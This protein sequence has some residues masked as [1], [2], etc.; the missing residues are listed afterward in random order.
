MNGEFVDVG[1]LDVEADV[2][3]GVPEVVVGGEVFRVEDVDDCFGE[4]FGLDEGCDVEVLDVVGGFV[5]VVDVFDVADDG[6]VFVGL[7]LGLDELVEKAVEFF[8]C[9]HVGVPCLLA[10]LVCGAAAPHEKF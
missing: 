4:D 9:G 7:F 8:D 10:F 5:F 1:V 3:D 2:D 6:G